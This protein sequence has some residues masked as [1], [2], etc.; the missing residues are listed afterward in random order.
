MNDVCSFSDRK[1]IIIIKSIK[2][3][4]QFLH[5]RNIYYENE[6]DLILLLKLL[7]V[8]FQKHIKFLQLL[9]VNKK[10]NMQE[11]N[12]ILNNLINNLIQIQILK[13]IILF[14]FQ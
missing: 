5:F 9:N 12:M 7:N 13:Q 4:N 1:L 3:F 2:L 10:L 6:N 14:H 8:F 11:N